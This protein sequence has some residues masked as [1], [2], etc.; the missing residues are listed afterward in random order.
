[1]LCV[2]V[3]KN[4]TDQP[5]VLLNSTSPLS[6]PILQHPKWPGLHAFLPTCQPMNG[7]PS[8]PL[9]SATLTRMSVHLT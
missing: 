8:K 5:E 9:P 7:I 2:I 4:G 3:L 6:S 1:M